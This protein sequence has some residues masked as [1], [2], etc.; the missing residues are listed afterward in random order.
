MEFYYKTNDWE[1]IEKKDPHFIEVRGHKIPYVVFENMPE[2]THDVKLIDA[3]LERATK[4]L[5]EMK[6]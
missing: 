6:K 3:E 2:K 1:A 4:K 5:W